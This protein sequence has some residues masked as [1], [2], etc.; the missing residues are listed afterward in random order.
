[1]VLEAIGDY[2]RGYRPG[3]KEYAGMRVPRNGFWDEH[4]M[5]QSWEPAWKAPTECTL[6]DRVSAR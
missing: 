3:A 5:P 4:I 1:M 2:G 6:Q